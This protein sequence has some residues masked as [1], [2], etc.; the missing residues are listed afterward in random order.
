MA[1]VD[2]K[3]A[4]DSAD[5]KWLNEIWKYTG[6]TAGSVGRSGTPVQAEYQKHSS[7]VQSREMRL[8]RP[9]DSIPHVDPTL[10]IGRA[11]KH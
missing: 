7:Y 1:R 8:P 11:A 9:S 3:K 6:S 10:A 5:H 2:I 4:Y